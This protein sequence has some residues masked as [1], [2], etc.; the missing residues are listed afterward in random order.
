M[1]VRRVVGGTLYLTLGAL[2]GLVSALAGIE[3]FGSYAAEKDRPWQVW[4]LSQSGGAHPYALAH[5]LAE[6][7]LPPATGQM[8]EFL[9]QRSDD[10]NVLAAECHYL[11]TSTG[12]TT[13]RWWSLLAASGRGERRA[14]SILSSGSA[15]AENDGT[16]YVAVSRQPQSG[17]WIEA[18]AS[19]A[20]TL[21]Y[22]AA[23]PAEVS[24]NRAPPPFTITRIGC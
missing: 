15:V 19:G 22:T 8:R 16:I 21:I 3:S 17:N 14:G 2:A 20:F 1:A 4:N 5:F 9:A 24:R 7:R 11:L 23:D 18:P 13:P 12:D 10:G 6:G